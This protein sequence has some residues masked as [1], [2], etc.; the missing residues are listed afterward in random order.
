MK[1]LLKVIYYTLSFTWGIVMTIIG[2]FAAIGLLV[3]GVKPEKVG[4]NYHFKVRERWGG[5]SLGLVI[6][7]D[8]TPSD[9]TMK[10][11]FGHTLQNCLFG[12]FFLFI[13]AASFIRYHYRNK[14]AASGKKLPPYDS[15]WYEEQAT[16]LGEQYF[17][18]FL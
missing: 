7:T 5:V 11:E 9:H 8:N 13:G 10:H 1:N 3:I 14:Q 18:Y 6:I 15:V 17:K 4:P 16:K 2:A 12:P